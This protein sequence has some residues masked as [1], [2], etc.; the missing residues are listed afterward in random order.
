MTE[1]PYLPQTP[2]PEDKNLYQWFIEVWK[3]L[4]VKGAL[5]GA[6]R[7]GSQDSYTGFE[8]DGTLVATGSA[9]TWNDINF[10]GSALKPGSSSP[11][12]A[13]V[14]GGLQGWTFDAAAVEEL[15]GCEEVLHDYKEGSDIIVHIHWRPTTTNTGTV[16][17]GLEYSW[18]NI[19]ATATST[20]TIYVEQA[21]TG[22]VGRHQIIPFPT[23]AGTGQ[24]IG[25]MFQCRLFRDA[26]NVADTY[27]GEAFMAQFGIHYER[28][29]LGSRGVA[30]K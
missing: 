21:S 12:W 18:T 9:T 15:Q 14:L 28:D 30:T 27:T 19:G 11:T 3:K 6:V 2:R 17:W 25:S 10:S 16:R 5:L 24:K 8:D 1:K 7:F 20:S 13:T 26:S 4:G 29:T 22:V 23:I